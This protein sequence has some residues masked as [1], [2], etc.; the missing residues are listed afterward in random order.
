MIENWVAKLKRKV[1]GYFKSLR[2]QTPEQLSK[3]GY[4]AD[5]I[6][7]FQNRVASKTRE[8]ALMEGRE[9]S[10]EPNVPKLLVNKLAKKKRNK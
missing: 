7:K 6:R 2:A 10:E 9:P 4:G 1:K 8:E 3:Q 5:D